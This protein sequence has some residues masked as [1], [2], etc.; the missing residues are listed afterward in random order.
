[1]R[2]TLYPDTGLRFV[3]AEGRI[4]VASDRLVDDMTEYQRTVYRLMRAGRAHA[5]LAVQAD[6]LERRFASY[7]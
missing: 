7:P 5:D 3:V 2:E 6:R 4:G 1:M